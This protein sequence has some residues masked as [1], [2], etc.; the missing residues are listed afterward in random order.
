MKTR[1]LITIDTAGYV[2]THG[3]NPHA[4]RPRKGMWAF[5]ID[6]SETVS[7]KYGTYKD[8]LAWAKAQATATI[9]VLP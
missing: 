3:M 2:R 6:A 7:V 9:K 8:A 5:S 4:A 1:T